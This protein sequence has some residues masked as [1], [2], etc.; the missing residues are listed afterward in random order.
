MNKRLMNLLLVTLLVSSIFMPIVQAKQQNTNW[1]SPI[2]I[3]TTGK[4]IVFGSGKNKITVTADIEYTYGGDVRYEHWNPK[5]ASHS[6]TDNSRTENVK[7]SGFEMDFYVNRDTN[8]IKFDLYASQDISV[9][10][11][12]DGTHKG[13]YIY[14]TEQLTLNLLDVRM[15]AD[16]FGSSGD[17]KKIYFTMKA[18]ERIDPLIT[19]NE[20]AGTYV[21]DALG[22]YAPGVVIPAAYSDNVTLHVPGDYDSNGTSMRDWQLVT[23]GDYTEVDADTA[24]FEWIL[25]NLREETSP[26]LTDNQ[27]NAAGTEYVVYDD[28]QTFWTIGAGSTLTNESSIVIKGVNSTK[29]LWNPGGT[30]FFI[31]SFGANDLDIT[32]FTYVNF[33]FKGNN[34]GLP[35]NF[36]MR[37][38]ADAD[39]LQW[40]FTDTSTKWARYETPLRLMTTTVG[41]FD[42]VIAAVDAI[43]IGTTA[44]GNRDKTVYF[45]RVTFDSNMWT[46]SELYIGDDTTSI[47]VY[48]LDSTGADPR[49]VFE[50]GVNGTTDASI[51]PGNLRNLEDEWLGSIAKAN[52]T[53]WT[54]KANTT[55]PVGTYGEFLINTTI[56]LPSGADRMILPSDYPTD[57]LEYWNQEKGIA[58]G[59]P[60]SKIPGYADAF[61]HRGGVGSTVI[62]SGATL[63]MLRLPYAT[64]SL[65]IEPTGQTGAS[66]YNWVLDTGAKTYSYEYY[67]D[68][69]NAAAQNATLEV[70][71]PDLADIATFT[72]SYWN[73]ATYVEFADFGVATITQPESLNGTSLDAAIYLDGLRTETKA[74]INSTAGL[75]GIADITYSNNYGLINRAGFTIELWEDDGVPEG[76]ADEIRLK[77]TM[78]YIDDG[79]ATYE[80]SGGDANQFWGLDNLDNSAIE[81]YDSSA[82]AAS[83]YL[84]L[85][86]ANKVDALWVTASADQSITAVEFNAT[87]NYNVLTDTALGTETTTAPTGETIQLT[88]DRWQYFKNIA[89]FDRAERTDVELGEGDGG[90]AWTYSSLPGAD[91]KIAFKV[92][93]APW[94]NASVVDVDSGRSQARFKAVVNYA[95]DPTWSYTVDL[96]SNVEAQYVLTLLCDFYKNSYNV[97]PTMPMKAS[98]ITFTDP[99][100]STP[101]NF[102]DTAEAGATAAERSDVDHLTI[103]GVVVQSKVVPFGTVA[104]GA[105]V[106][107]N[108]TV[109][110]GIP[111]NPV[112]HSVA[113]GNL[114]SSTFVYDEEVLTVVMN[115]L[116][117]QSTVV[118][119]CSTYG[120]PSR[121]VG[122]SNWSYNAV[123]GLATFTLYHSSPKTVKIY[124]QNL[125][126]QGIQGLSY[127]WSI[128]PL[129][130]LFAALEAG[131]RNILDVR[132][133]ALAIVFA[134]AALLLFAIQTL[135]A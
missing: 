22:D 7:A 125:S 107:Q 100:T 48:N 122:T 8:E 114:T 66:F 88:A 71:I 58:G 11:H 106:T 103:N 64:R 31:H 101:Y 39:I 72:L 20:V 47:E 23:A 119:D 60:W 50:Y 76:G 80:F 120:K 17:D 102:T 1:V 29:I 130:V 116:T 75:A 28:T 51:Y 77:F 45:D 4:G 10:L 97:G 46:P 115:R 42:N 55:L 3:K 110:L 18:G 108:I 104:A 91:Q 117:G 131:K 86:T 30:G 92:P 63:G 44:F 52:A 95:V 123:T 124:W 9:S 6:K 94:Q 90:F 128:F 14:Q 15:Y 61:L 96:A 27:T 98:T 113:N 33:W 81:L 87:G 54:I 73:G 67:L 16:N 2:D 127:L 83:P 43:V 56:Q 99:R 49:L 68:N 59:N 69:D 34:T 53:D 40:T 84:I 12:I 135:G 38:N 13:N 132:Y 126:Y 41:S 105:G 129:I 37:T 109:N 21:Y 112:V 70:N 93:L 79:S 65:A 19:Y 134:V 78:T 74:M 57:Q 85:L 133:V 82:V 26:S 89:Q 24:S 111:N 5:K 121:V 25:E 36:E 62:N 32:N 118:V 35:I